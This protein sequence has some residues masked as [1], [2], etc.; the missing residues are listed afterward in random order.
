MA[1]PLPHPAIRPAPWC[2]CAH[3]DDLWFQVARHALQP[4]LPPLLHQLQPAQ[5]HVRLPRSGHGPPRPRRIGRARRQGVLLHRRR[6]VSATAT[7]SPI[8][9]LTL[10][11]G[12]A[13]VLTNGTVFKDEWLQRLAPGRGG[14]AVQPGVPRL[15]RR[16]H[17]GGRTIPVRGAGTFERA[18][19]G[20]RQLLAH[21]FLPI[22]T[23]ARTRDDQDDG[24]L[25]DGFVRAAAG[26]TATTGRASRSCRRLRLG[27]EAERQRGY[28][29]DERV[30]PEMMEGFDPGQLL[31]NHSRIVTDRGVYVC[32]ILIEAPDARLGRTLAEALR[33]LSAAASRLLHLLPVR[34]AR[35]PTRR[36]ATRCL[37]RPHR[38]LRRHLQ[39]L[40]RPGGGPATMRAARRGG[41][42]LPRRSRRLRAASRSRLSA[43]ARARRRCASRAT[44]TTRSATTWP[45]ASAATPIRATTIS[46]A[47]ATTTPSRTPARP[48][49]PGCGHCRRSAALQLGRYRA[50]A[51]PRQ[52][53]AR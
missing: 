44:T 18:L 14:V 47:S 32:P 27:A 31:C 52:P 9:E 15:D 49:A 20:V 17:G 35:A 42:L 21:G 39:Q 41:R 40:P 24:D 22:V 19:R 34:D 48:T 51:V 33:P 4:D 50:A 45:T 6:A 23:V 37:S 28:R 11:Y 5:S 1:I 29:D 10:R 43:A 53:A 25:F 3:L 7:W 8:L 2:R 16:L 30:T 46:P 36:R 26:A 12:P 13:T 38:R